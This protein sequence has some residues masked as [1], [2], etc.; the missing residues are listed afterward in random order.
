VI[1]GTDGLKHG[2]RRAGSSE[3]NNIVTL[4]AVKIIKNSI[5]I[6]ELIP[7]KAEAKKAYVLIGAA[8]NL[9][10]DL[11][12]VRSVINKYSNELT[13]MDVLY[14]IIAKKESAALNAPRFTENPLSVTDSAIS[15]A[16]LLDYVNKHKKSRHPA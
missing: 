13:S 1:I 2:L 6:N 14:A 9:N 3:A 12:I 10:G 5:K 11:Y 15:I 8:K 7:S 16:D 4:K